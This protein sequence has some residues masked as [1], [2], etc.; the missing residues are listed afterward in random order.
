MLVLGTSG[1]SLLTLLIQKRLVDLDLVRSI[2]AD[3]KKLEKEIKETKSEEKKLSKLS[4]Q[5]DLQKKMLGLTMKP[6]MLSS[7]PVLLAVVFLSSAFEALV[8][9]LPVALP[10]I[11][12]QIGWFGVFIM[13]SVLST[14]VFRKFLGLDFY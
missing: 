12:A 8:V 10:F 14:L 2:K 9:T 1:L 4:K 7:L 5:I 3:I 6:M 13:V 11:G